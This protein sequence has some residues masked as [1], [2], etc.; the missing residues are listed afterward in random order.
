MNT[1][2]SKKAIGTSL[3][4]MFIAAVLFTSVAF[5]NAAASE[6]GQTSGNGKKLGHTYGVGNGGTP[7]GHQ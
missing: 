5:A 1:V 4:A 3:F 7:P 6:K 2:Y